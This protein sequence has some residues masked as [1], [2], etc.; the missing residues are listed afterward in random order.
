MRYEAVFACYG[1]NNMMRFFRYFFAY[2]SIFHRRLAHLLAFF[3]PVL[4]LL[5]FSAVLLRYGFAFN[6][7]WLTELQSVVHAVIFLGMAAYTMGSNGHVR[8]D[9]FYRHFSR[10]MAL[11]TDLCGYLCLVSCM[12]GGLF[13][14]SYDFVGESWRIREGSSEYNGLPGIFLLKT[15][16]I[17]YALSL[18]LEG[19]AS[20]FRRIWR[21]RQYRHMSRCS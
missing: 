21:Y 18:C 4:A 2:I 7:A 14:F 19:A 6:P 15:C 16:I 5:T 20:L 11:L 10:R 13:Y 17:F 9:A 8:V 12:G 3:V 1:R